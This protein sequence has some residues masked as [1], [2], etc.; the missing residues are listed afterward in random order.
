MNSFY[1]I[2]NNQLAAIPRLFWNS[3]KEKVENEIFDAGNDFSLS[4]DEDDKYHAIVIA[5]DGIKKLNPSSIYLIDQA[6]TY[7][8]EHLE[9]ILLKFPPLL[10]RLA[11]LIG[12][13]YDENSEDQSEAVKNVSK[14]IWK[15]NASYFMKKTAVIEGETVV[16]DIENDKQYT[17]L[18]YI[19]DEFGSR[20]QH[21]DSPN[22]V[23]KHFFYV[24]KN[25]SMTVMYPIQDI[26]HGDEVF[27]NYVENVTGDTNTIDARLYPW[28]NQR[29]NI[30]NIKDDWI[31]KLKAIKDEKDR[32]NENVQ[33]EQQLSLNNNVADT[34][35]WK[36]FTTNQFVLKYLTNENFEFVDNQDSADIIFA[37]THFKDFLSHQDK[38]ISQYPNEKILLCKDLFAETAMR[39]A[40]F[41][42]ENSS[43][44]QDVLDNRGP[45]FIPTTFNLFNELPEFIKYFKNRE[46][47]KDLDNTWIVKPWNLA[48]S[49]D[50]TVTDNLD[51]IISLA[52]TGPK[53]VCKYIDNPVLHL[54]KDIG[55]VK[56]DYR[57]VV[58]LKKVKP[59]EVYIH[60]VF[61]IRF[62]N[63]PFQ[64][65]DFYDF[66]TH[67]THMWYKGCE[68]L[69]VPYGEYIPLF[70]EMYPHLKW[71]SIQADIYSCI[72]ELMVG[73]TTKTPPHGLG[74][75]D[76]CRAFYGIDLML[77][78]KDKDHTSVQ[79]VL[80]EAN[81]NSDI[82]RA[83]R[84]MPEFVNEMFELFFL[85][86]K[87]DNFIQL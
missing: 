35:I 60:K 41:K 1:E 19:L 65:K 39:S 2:H 4:I 38:Y 56:Q 29:L 44:P 43:M 64:L 42:Y 85:D 20:I 23:F 33:A 5:E 76:K 69:E 62:G 21:C 17:P 6:L 9:S 22:V 46:S 45:L 58:Y 54:R 34:K 12:I 77:K 59:L 83:C 82:T 32:C 7:E 13:E 49:L 74:Q 55:W 75:L 57:F 52:E 84:D 31:N 71:E 40:I 48:R 51:Q 8:A 36:V 10:K 86:Q 11:D 3:L 68:L 53:V 15:Y 24:P 27:R 25:M 70:D 28:F 72:K 67:Y 37:M 61:W 66:Q 79:P 30:E 47:K 87:S 81:F 18:W 14:N 50:H 78:W 80:L 73:A 26:H 16:E 63:K